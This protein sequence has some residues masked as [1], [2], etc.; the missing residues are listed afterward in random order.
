MLQRIV[1]RDR[2]KIL[3]VEDYGSLSLFRGYA[4]I[5][6]ID[7]E[8]RI[9][10]GVMTKATLDNQDEIV[11][12]EA[13][14]EAVKDFQKW[15]N[16]REMHDGG[17]A[18]GVVK[19]L[20]LDHVNKL[21]R[22]EA[23]VVD[24]SAWN[25]VKKGVYKGF[26]IGGK[27]LER[28]KEFAPA[29][30]K[31]ISKVKKY[32]LNEV[33]L[34]D[35]PAHPECIFEVVKRDGY[36]NDPLY[37]EMMSVE[38]KVPV[39]RNKVLTDSAISRL[40]D[41]AF[42]LVKVER[43]NGGLHKRRYYCMPDKIHARSVLSVLSNSSLSKRD[44]FR[45]HKRAMTI[46]GKSHRKDSCPFCFEIQKYQ[47]LSEVNNKM[48]MRKRR[49]AEAEALLRDAY[50]EDREGMDPQLDRHTRI[51]QLPN[52]MADIQQT[53]NLGD[54][55]D[56]PGVYDAERFMRAPVLASSFFPGLALNHVVKGNKG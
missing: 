7:E 26:S 53:L 18:S 39:F 19:S 6:K 40:S 2:G 29:L 30:G 25:K 48:N 42:G 36:F 17:K 3:S 55:T 13:T 11:E 4:A 15:M 20:T 51:M 27:A 41:S 47:L 56:I 8:K 37:K 12:W 14:V 50:N 45:V 34:V 32:I 28:V 16:L 33:S 9:V 44:Q 35:R 10:I 52:H 24:D 43:I 54:G 5:T 23:E 22:V 46:L 38:S 1:K 31:V 49:V 21:V